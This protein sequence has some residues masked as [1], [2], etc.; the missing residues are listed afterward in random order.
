MRGTKRLVSFH[1]VQGAYHFC[2]DILCIFCDFE[3]HTSDDR[4]FD[5]LKKFTAGSDSC[6]EDEEADEGIMV[7][8]RVL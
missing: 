4:L 8:T 3:I 7:G 1:C 6:D 2:I 5:A